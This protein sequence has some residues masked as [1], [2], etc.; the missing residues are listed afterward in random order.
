MTAYYPGVST[1]VLLP[2]GSVKRNGKG[3]DISVG[4]DTQ[5]I[6]FKINIMPS[7]YKLFEA[8]R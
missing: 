1:T 7:S 3:G 8:K 6:Q 5:K 4:Y 2:A